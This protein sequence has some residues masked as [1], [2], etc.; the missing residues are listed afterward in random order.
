MRRLDV[1]AAVFH[2][3]A[4]NKGYVIGP[5]NGRGEETIPDLLIV[6]LVIHE[7]KKNELG[8][9]Q[10]SGDGRVRLAMQVS[11]LCSKRCSC[12]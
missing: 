9:L 3:L 2:G 11:T 4:M 6:Y 10:G 5:M 8:P 1:L 7:E 12:N